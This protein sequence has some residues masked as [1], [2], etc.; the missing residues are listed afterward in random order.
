MQYIF[1]LLAVICLGVMVYLL[2]YP[3]LGYR[4][5]TGQVTCDSVFHAGPPRDSYE[6]W[7]DDDGYTVAGDAAQTHDICEPRR[8]QRLGMALAVSVPMNVFVTV[9][10]LRSPRIRRAWTP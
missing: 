3:S 9:T 7:D 4:V 8:Q 6:G 5:S 10:L 1:G 2:L